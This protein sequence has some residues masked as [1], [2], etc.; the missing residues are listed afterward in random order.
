MGRLWFKA[1]KYG[2]GWYPCSWEGWGVMGSVVAFILVFA[3]EA[4][5]YLSSKEGMLLYVSAVF[6]VIGVFMIIAYKKGER[7][8]FRWGK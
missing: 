2:W 8:K 7:P 1:R 6:C 3:L 4:K 5:R